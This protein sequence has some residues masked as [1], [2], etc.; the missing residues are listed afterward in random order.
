MNVSRS[1]L[2]LA[3][4]AVAGC[5]ARSG[6]AGDLDL[7]SQGGGWPV[8]AASEGAGE[9]GWGGAGGGQPKAP[10]WQPKAP[11]WWRQIGGAHLDQVGGV[12]LDAAGSAIVAGDFRETL[13]L[14]GGP[15]TAAGIASLFVA[16]FDPT[17]E[18]LWSR[19]FGSGLARGA[20]IAVDAQGN[21]L[22]IGEFQRGDIDFGGGALTSIGERDLFIAKLSPA[23]EHLW[24]RSFGT[25]GSDRA[26]AVD[27]DPD[28]NVLLAAGFGDHLLLAKLSPAGELLWARETGAISTR[29]AGSPPVA[30]AAVDSGG[31]LVITG[32][33][34]GVARL[35]GEPLTSAGGNDGFVAKYSG[36]DGAHVWS[37]RF[38]DRQSAVSTADAGRGVAVDANRD[39]IVTG[40]FQGNIDFGAGR[41]ASGEG[42]GADAF[43]AKLAG[44]DGSPIWAQRLGGASLD[45]GG[46]VG[47]DAR[48][49]VTIAAE[50]DRPGSASGEPLAGGAHLATYGA[51]GSFLSARP[52]PFADGSYGSVPMALD[53]RGAALLAVTFHG[54]ATI[55][56]TT[57]ESLGRSDVLLV[58]YGP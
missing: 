40:H 18:H 27:C 29:R 31:D 36:E 44:P 6:A 47:V 25:E 21:V 19:A 1:W 46:S 30:D 7:G 49:S 14:G 43:V 10:A 57:V 39:V 3:F 51:E 20:D 8:S 15:L 37:K 41:L 34:N 50:L 58:Y 38:G 42:A 55:A 48:G 45:I 28:G 23:G 11:A 17:G 35:G 2:F 52:I 13:D 5:G 54:A 16:K 22:L 4:A 32:H 56:D 33:F 12:A 53:R 26:G 9:H 24:S